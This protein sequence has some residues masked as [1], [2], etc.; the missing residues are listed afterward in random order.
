[1]K[2][3]F[4]AILTAA[5]LL[6]MGV[7]AAAEGTLTV[8][9]VGAVNVDADTATVSLGIRV[10]AE[11]VISTQ[12]LANERANAII[13]GLEAMG[14][15]REAINTNGIGIY[16]NFDYSGSEE[17]ITGYTAYN[18]IY[19]TLTDVERVGEVIDAAFAAGANSLDYVEYAARDTEEAADKALVLAVG[20][21]KEKAQ[22]LADAAGVKLGAILQISDTQDTGYVDNN[23]RM[24]A[25]TEEA[26]DAGAGTTVLA[27][28]QSVTAN[29]T[30]TFAIAE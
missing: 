8:S 22:V 7:C 9:G 26:D 12:S 14:I 23:M 24:Y 1:M 25:K 6:M 17:R 13:D 29:I 20:S 21:A 2:I 5:M 16:P 11:D 19:I 10:I 15:G 4:I 30:V 3:R 18:N 28:K 27:S